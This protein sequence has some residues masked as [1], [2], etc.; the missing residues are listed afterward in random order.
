[1]ARQRVRARKLLAAS[2]T[3]TLRPEVLG[4]QDVPRDAHRVAPAFLARRI[5]ARVGLVRVGVVMFVG[6]R[7]EVHARVDVVGERLST[8]RERDNE[9][10]RRAQIY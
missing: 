2:M 7:G 9:V 1:M 10:A 4:G 8:A 5:A 6:V 3:G